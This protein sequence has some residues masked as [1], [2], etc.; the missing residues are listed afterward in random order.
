MSIKRIARRILPKRINNRPAGVVKN[1]EGNRHS[2]TDKAALA[3]KTKTVR[4]KKFNS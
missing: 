1:G 2:S 4:R 3:K